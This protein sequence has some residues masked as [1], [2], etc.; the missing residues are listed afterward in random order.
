MPIK[1]GD[2]IKVEYEGTLED[3][4]V[5]DSSE[6]HGEPLEFEVGSGKVL[7]G[8]EEAVVGMEKDEEKEFTLEPSD[9]YGD[10]NPDLTRDIPKDQIP[11]EEELKPGMVLV[12][13]MPNGFQISAIITEVHEETVKIDLNHPLAGKT[14]SF[15]VKVLDVSS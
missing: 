11:Q 3:G 7:T 15:K 13:S 10:H 14:L 12:M 5:F 2:T 6:K 8:F 1:K 4:T 9:A